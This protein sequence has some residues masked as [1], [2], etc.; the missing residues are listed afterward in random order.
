MI[1]GKFIM[2][3]SEFIEETITVWV[4]ENRDD[5]KSYMKEL[6]K[7][8]ARS[9]IVNITKKLIGSIDDTKVKVKIITDSLLRNNLIKEMSEVEMKTR[10]MERMDAWA[11]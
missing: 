9:T 5:M 8:F 10:D 1:S 11:V 4:E 7:N 3:I 2:N 6:F